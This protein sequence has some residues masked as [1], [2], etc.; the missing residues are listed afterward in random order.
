MG[1]EGLFMLA[2][3]CMVGKGGGRSRG[4]RRK[5]EHTCLSSRV[6]TEHENTHFF[7]SEQPKPHLGKLTTHDCWCARRNWGTNRLF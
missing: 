5:W 3:V 2:M 4:W 1:K 7:V 6:Q